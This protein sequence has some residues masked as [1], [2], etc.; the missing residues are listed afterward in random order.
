LPIIEQK[1]SQKVQTHSENTK[2]LSWQRLINQKG[3]LQNAEA[4]CFGV[5]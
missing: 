5:T 4:S 3:I 1:D 2:G